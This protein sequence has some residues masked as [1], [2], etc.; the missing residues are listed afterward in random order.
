MTSITISLETLEKTRDNPEVEMT[1]LS[2][3]STVLRYCVMNL[4]VSVSQT[5]K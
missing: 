4:I 3:V 2:Y 1:A 5:V